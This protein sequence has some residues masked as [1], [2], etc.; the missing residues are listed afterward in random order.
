MAMGFSSRISLLSVS[1]IFYC[2][3]LDSGT[4][5]NTISS[6]QLIQDP[7]TISSNDGMF[8]L[9]FF[10][11]Q[12]TTNRYVGIWYKTRSLVVWVA[13]R[14]Q[15]LKDSKGSVT[16]AEDSNLVVLDA[17]AHVIWSS[18]VVSKSSSKSSTS[19]QLLD[20]GNLVLVVVDDATGKTVFCRVSSILLMFS[21]QDVT[22][23]QQKNCCLRGF[24]PRNVDEWNRQKWTSGCV[25]K[26]ALKCEN[27][28]VDSKEDGFLNLQKVKAPNFADWSSARSKDECRSQASARRTAIVLRIHIMMGLVELLVFDAEKLAYATDDLNSSNKL[29]EGGFDP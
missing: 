19:A 18:N 8:T 5:I 15:P 11:L 9:G 14:N 3:C 17:T 20:S 23:K 25:R 22:Y 4:A 16:I 21:C 27:G 12:N 2:L 26:K 28:T 10:S 1:V 29:G 13:N 6:A 7:E 24:E